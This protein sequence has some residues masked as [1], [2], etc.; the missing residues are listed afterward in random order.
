MAIG[1][2]SEVQ[3]RFNSLLPAGDAADAFNIVEYNAWHDSQLEPWQ[4]DLTEVATTNDD[5]FFNNVATSVARPAY[6]DEDD[7]PSSHSA[8][9]DL[10][11][12]TVLAPSRPSSRSR[13]RGLPILPI[14]VGLCA[15]SML[16]GIGFCIHLLVNKPA[17]QVASADPIMGDI[18]AG[19]AT[20]KNK[21]ER[22][23]TFD[24]IMGS[25]VGTANQEPPP[26]KDNTQLP[27]FDMTAT[28]SGGNNMSPAGDADPNG[29]MN[30]NMN[31]SMANGPMTP[32]GMKPDE[33]K[34]D[35]MAPENPPSP[36][37]PPATPPSTPSDTPTTPPTPTVPEPNSPARPQLQQHRRHP[38]PL[39]MTC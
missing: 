21:P 5:E 16:G 9:P 29:N 25:M 28:N 1:A 2:S 11:H 3:A 7:S 37:T 23:A 10:S 15:I 13:K 6:Y 14:F 34:P 32:A 30:G 22:P 17:R 8:V 20:E 27:S 12:S 24:P 35:G 38:T 19:K 18:G 26:A 4:E 39:P 36:N 31:P 33:M